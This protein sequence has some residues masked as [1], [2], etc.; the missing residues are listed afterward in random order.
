MKN[1]ATRQGQELP[2]AASD[3]LDE[4]YKGKDARSKFKNIPMEEKELTSQMAAEMSFSGRLEGV[5]NQAVAGGGM[6][7]GVLPIMI[8]IPTSGQVYRFA[9]T[10]VKPE[11]PLTFS[12]VYTQL[13]FTSLLKWFIFVVLV[14][15]VYILIRRQTGLWKWIKKQYERMKEFYRKHEATIRRMARSWMTPFVL[16]GLIFIFWSVSGLL[17]LILLFLFWVSVVYQVLNFRRKKKEV[18]V[19]EPEMIVDETAKRKRKPGKKNS[20]TDK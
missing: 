13:W 11:D 4:A 15:I 8:R 14:L 10:I 19:A 7:T 1:L 6:G 12:V 16:L 3:E 9:R 5:A 18:M 17:T 2:M 20:P